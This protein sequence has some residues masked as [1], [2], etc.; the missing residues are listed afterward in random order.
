[1][2]ELVCDRNRDK[3]AF[4]TVGQEGTRMAGR[5]LKPITRPGQAVGKKSPASRARAGSLR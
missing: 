2:G 5:E 1:M 4:P 3:G